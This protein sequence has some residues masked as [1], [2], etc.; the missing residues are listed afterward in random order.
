[1]FYSP[2]DAHTALWS[3]FLTMYSLL[4]TAWITISQGTISRLYSVL[5]VVLAGSPLSIYLF[6]YAIV[7]FWHRSHKLNHLVGDG[8]LL[9]R[10][11]AIVAGLLWIVLLV[12]SFATDG[13]QF[14]QQSC[15]RTEERGFVDC[16]YLIPFIFVGVSVE[17]APVLAVLIIF[18]LASTLLAWALVLFIQRRRIWPAGQ[19]WRPRFGRVW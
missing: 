8:Q 17:V 11:L 14:S 10:M 13:S 19:T 2:K 16:I 3:Q 9:S 12:F 18:P 6:I 7:S 5:A 1:M 4:L 15:D